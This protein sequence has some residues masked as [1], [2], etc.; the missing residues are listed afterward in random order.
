MTALRSYDWQEK[1]YKIQTVNYR[2]LQF[3][4]PFN[5]PKCPRTPK[6]RISKQHKVTLKDDPR[7]QSLRSKKSRNGL[8]IQLQCVVSRTT[9]HQDRL[10]Q[11]QAHAWSWWLSPIIPATQEAEIRR[12]AVQSQLGQIVQETLS[13]KHTTQ[14][15]ASRLLQVVECLPSKHE[16]LSSNPVLLPLY[17]PQKKKKNTNLRPCHSDLDA[18]IWPHPHSSLLIHLF[19]WYLWLKL[20]TRPQTFWAEGLQLWMGP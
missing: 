1:I 20:L 18:Y 8:C 14:N 4:W 15:R 19:L 16:A 12:I 11:R 6:Q 17:P 10:S 3:K 2:L 7:Y 13:W 9:N 5:L